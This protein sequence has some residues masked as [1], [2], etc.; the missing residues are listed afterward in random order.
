[1]RPNYRSKTPGGKDIAFNVSSGQLLDPDGNPSTDVAQTTF[2]QQTGQ[3]EIRISDRAKG[4]AVMRAVVHEIAEAGAI[5][6]GVTNRADILTDEAINGDQAL[7][8]SRLS[9]HDRGRIAELRYLAGLVA[10]AKTGLPSRASKDV[11]ALLRALG[12]VAGRPDPDTGS[13]LGRSKGYAQR[14]AALDPSVQLIVDQLNTLPRVGSVP[15]GVPGKLDSFWKAAANAGFV[16][17]L[18][19]GALAGAAVVSGL[20]AALFPV[21]AVIFFAESSGAFASTFLERRQALH[22]EHAATRE[23][24]KHALSREAVPLIGRQAA[25]LRGRIEEANHRSQRYESG[26]PVP[27]PDPGHA[28]ETALERAAREAKAA[29]EAPIP[30]ESIEKI[31]WYRPIQLAR[32]LGQDAWFMRTAPSVVVR[33]GVAALAVVIVGAPVPLAVGFAVANLGALWAGRLEG[34]QGRS[35]APGQERERVAREKIDALMA[36]ARIERDTSPL[37][38]RQQALAERRDRLSDLSNKLDL[39]RDAVLRGAPLAA[40]KAAAEDA[41]AAAQPDPTAPDPRT[42]SRESDL[43]AALHVP[44]I[45][46]RHDDGSGPSRP[47][48][49]VRQATRALSTLKAEDVKSVEGYRADVKNGIVEVSYEGQILPLQFRVEAVP[50]EVLSKDLTG[51]DS[52]VARVL[53]PNPG[54]AQPDAHTLQIYEGATGPEVIWAAR[55]ALDQLLYAR[56]GAPIAGSQL[57][58]GLTSGPL[59]PLSALDRARADDLARALDHLDAARSWALNRHNQD[60]YYEAALRAAGLDLTDPDPASAARR[61]AALDDELLARLQARELPSTTRPL[62]EHQK[63]WLKIMAGP[64]IGAPAL[65]VGFAALGTVPMADALYLPRLLAEVAAPLAYGAT[66]GFFEWNFNRLTE[67]AQRRALAEQPAAAQDIRNAERGYRDT[68]ADTL[69]GKEAEIREVEAALA[70]RKAVLDAAVARSERNARL[71]SSPLRRAVDALFRRADPNPVS[72]RI[73]PVSPAPTPPPP[74][75]PPP[76]YE[77]PPAKPIPGWWAFIGM[78]AGSI[79]ASVGAY[80]GIGTIGDG[81]SLGEIADVENWKDIAGPE[82][83]DPR[84]ALLVGSVTGPAILLGTVLGSAVE[85]WF[86][87][88]QAEL[89]AAREGALAAHEADRQARD[90]RSVLDPLRQELAEAADELS[91]KQAAQADRRAEQDARLEQAAPL[92]GP[93]TLRAAGDRVRSVMGGVFGD[94]GSDETGDPDTGTSSPEAPHGEQSSSDPSRGPD[95]TADPT[96][97]DPGKPRTPLPPVLESEEDFFNRMRT[98][99]NTTGWDDDDEWPVPVIAQPSPPPKMPTKP[100]PPP[101]Q[102]EPQPAPPEDSIKPPKPAPLPPVPPPYCPPE[103]EPVSPPVAPAPPVDEGPQPAPPPLPE[104]P[105]LP[106]PVPPIPPVPPVPVPPIPPIPPIPVPP[107]PPVPVP[108]IPPVPPPHFGNRPTVVWWLDFVDPWGN[109]HLIALLQWPTPNGGSISLVIWLIFPADSSAPVVVLAELVGTAEPLALREH[110]AAVTDTVRTVLLDQI[111]D[112]DPAGLRWLVHHGAFSTPD[113]TLAEMFHELTLRF[114]G[115]RHW[116]D[117]VRLLGQA[118]VD[119]LVLA[120]NLRPIPEVLDLLSALEPAHPDVAPP[121]QPVFPLPEQPSAPQSE[122]PNAKPEQRNGVKLDE[123]NPVGRRASSSDRP[124]VVLIRAGVGHGRNGSDTGTTV[125]WRDRAIVGPAPLD[126][127]RIAAIE[128]RLGIRLPTDYLDVVRV[129]QGGAPDRGLIALPDGTVTALSMLL[130]FQDEPA[131]F[132]LVRIVENSDAFLGKF[133]PF[134]VDPYGQFLCFD[135]RGDSAHSWAATGW[136]RPVVLH[137]TSDPH[138]EPVFVAGSFTELIGS[139]QDEFVTSR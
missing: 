74:A 85:R 103:D 24:L 105:A 113:A 13:F 95:Q 70:A 57:T 122:E 139:L 93:G 135:Y 23:Q 123:H 78:T 21:A 83:A 134:A 73:T 107:I 115:V 87:G 132:N 40:V 94:R 46:G 58:D 11:D 64:A 79:L 65:I 45:P 138:A 110:T 54:A 127:A 32:S 136:N 102:P 60:S 68:V 108:P 3:W 84:T 53:P 20:G 63:K 86:A 5:L 71:A 120:L 98:E 130:H 4:R 34:N 106:P 49:V 25:D 100:K 66:R 14:R 69:A 52:P 92:R 76:G 27:L 67:A 128:G 48:R 17:A 10:D 118:E 30:D 129:H 43:A 19:A 72:G 90:Q 88:K 61:R 22:A 39:L 124:D 117:D 28:R 18:P 126:D 77:V 7:S 91:G 80:T 125:K 96:K 112:L 99:V 44:A 6:D 114:D 12:L 9:P 2:N 36:E 1:M 15:S 16:G 59:G 121:E 97:S 81:L 37:L 116:L 82:G 89:A 75:A 29:L 137:S 119:Q 62:L 55:M 47:S 38:E 50:A 111:P 31:P 109:H 35:L 131:D 101:H 8:P 56:F 33:L 41:A 133:I 51:A 26:N 104:P 42:Q